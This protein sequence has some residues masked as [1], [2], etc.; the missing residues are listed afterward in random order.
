MKSL[1]RGIRLI[2]FIWI[3]LVVI[4][5]ALGFVHQARKSHV[6]QSPVTQGEKR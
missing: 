3:G 6:R 4:A 5:I 1:I 2:F